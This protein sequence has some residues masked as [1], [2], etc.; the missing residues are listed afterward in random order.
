MANFAE[1]LEKLENVDA[2]GSMK[3]FD[4]MGNVCGL[5]E[6]KPGSAGSFRVYYHAALKWGGIGQKGAQEALELFAEHTDDARQHPGKHPNIDLLFDII[7]K[8]TVYSVRC[9]P[10]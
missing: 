7:Q 9:Y 3:L 6:N 8:D 5:I 1:N 4:E 2:F 10:V